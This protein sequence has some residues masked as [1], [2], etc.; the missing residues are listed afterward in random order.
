M[1]F[2]AVI[3]I[4]VALYLILKIS[5]SDQV[6]GAIKQLTI[7]NKTNDPYYA[8]QYRELDDVDNVLIKGSH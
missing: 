1:K 7:K 2:S 4:L 6:G 8:R 3:L 5:K